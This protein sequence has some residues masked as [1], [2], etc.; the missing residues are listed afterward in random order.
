MFSVILCVFNILTQTIDIGENDVTIIDHIKSFLLHDF[1][2]IILWDI[3]GLLYVQ[4]EEDEAIIEK[5]ESS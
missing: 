3:F 4:V 1:D 5:Q 2:V